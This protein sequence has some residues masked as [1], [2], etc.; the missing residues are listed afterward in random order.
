MDIICTN[1]RGYPSKMLAFTLYV[2]IFVHKMVRFGLLKAK[3][4][5]QVISMELM[6]C[7]TSRILDCSAPV[8]V[9]KFR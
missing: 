1:Y 8:I 7:M 9:G 6:T 4:H 5:L 3:P 2:L